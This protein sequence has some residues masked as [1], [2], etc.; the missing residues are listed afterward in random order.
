M[1]GS[2]YF[3]TVC[4]DTMAVANEHNMGKSIMS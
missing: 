4:I 2:N 1:I 3:D